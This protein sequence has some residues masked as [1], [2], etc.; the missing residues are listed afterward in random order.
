M[1]DVKGMA[2]CTIRFAF[3]D[4]FSKFMSTLH[5][6]DQD[7]VMTAIELIL[8]PYGKALIDEGWLKDLGGGLFEF[9]VGPTRRKIRRR[10][11]QN[12]D[13][14]FD[15]DLLVRIFCLFDT[16]TEIVILHS[17]DKT[18]DRSR[19]TQKSEISIARELLLL[20]R[21]SLEF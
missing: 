15:A 18:I 2:P 1:N 14:F 12:L 6:N 3:F 21:S 9:R 17:Y 20:T 16:E 10:T 11:N 13:N 7:I 19:S 8:R 4:D 5:P